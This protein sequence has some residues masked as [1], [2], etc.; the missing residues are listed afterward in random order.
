MDGSPRQRLPMLQGAHPG[1]VTS[2]GV[3]WHRRVEEGTRGDFPQQG[4]RFSV[5]Q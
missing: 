4:F 1:D 5:L 3:T 2:E